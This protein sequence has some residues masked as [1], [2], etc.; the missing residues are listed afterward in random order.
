MNNL[1]KKMLIFL[2]VMAAIAAIGWLG[3]K[4]YKS[5][6]ERRLVAQAQRYLAKKDFQSASLCLQH[7]LQL[8]PLSCPASESMA[9]TLEMVGLPAALKW[10]IHTAELQTNN[11][12]YRFA[13][14]RTALKMQDSSSAAWALAGIEKRAA[15]SATYYKLMGALDAERKD[16]LG[17]ESNYLEALRLEPTNETVTL[18]LATIRLAS[19]NEAVV[20]AARTALEQIPAQSTLRA[21]ALR[22]LI[23]DA[24]LHKRADQAL[25]YSNEILDSPQAVFDDKIVRLQLLRAAMR[26]DYPAWFDS[27]KSHAEKSPAQAYALGRWMANANG[28]TNALRWLQSLPVSTRTN[29]PVPMV[30]SDCQIAMK[31]W[32]G[33]LSLVENKDWGQAEPLRSA[34]ES[35]AR[36]SLGDDLAA[37]TAWRKAL[38]E[39]SHRLDQLSRLAQLTSRWSWKLENTEVLKEITVEFP[40]ERWAVNEL[41]AELYEQGNTIELGE[42][43]SK[44]CDVDPSDAKMKNCL[45]S[46]FLLRKNELE[47][48]YRLAGEAYSSSTNNPFFISTY[49]YSLLLQN[50]QDEALKVVS[51]IRPEYLQIPSIS[52]YYGVIQAQ[53]GHKDLAKGPLERAQMAKLLPEEKQMVQMAKASL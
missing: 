24:A 4:T 45:A 21:T 30:I 29:D 17:A 53:A 36:R 44:V 14:A 7:A 27:L 32:G 34:L 52:A 28:P 41:V 9:D 42:V 19:T 49:A 38:A 43:L 26:A 48:A 13:W 16:Y 37:Q 39:S 8:N 33:L 23:D 15:S 22:C 35:L 47:K 18:N 50:R 20:A 31:D 2:L 25:K 1:T 10:R 5:A 6:T 51:G 46:V 3:R 40:R 12:E 11:L